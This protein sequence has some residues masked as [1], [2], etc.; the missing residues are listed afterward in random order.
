MSHSSFH[1]RIVQ[2]CAG[3]ILGLGPCFP[4]LRWPS[5][6]AVFA[7]AAADAEMAQAIPGDTAGALKEEPQ[8]NKPGLVLTGSNKAELKLDPEE[9]AKNAFEALQAQA[10]AGVSPDNFRSVAHE[11]GKTILEKHNG[12]LGFL[13][14]VFVKNDHG[15][16]FA[17]SLYANF[18]TNRSDLPLVD[19]AKA[20]PGDATEQFVLQLHDLSYFLES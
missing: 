17:E 9:L 11:W 6:L 2:V 12:P 5:F 13:M 10:C 7:M 4:G 19:S 3:D 15:K 18:S 8:D 1:A 16:S 20:L 14:E